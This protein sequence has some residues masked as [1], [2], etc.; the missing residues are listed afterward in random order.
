MLC[1][2]SL[3]WITRKQVLYLNDRTAIS[4]LKRKANW[5]SCW[6]I[7]DVLFLSEC[8]INLSRTLYTKHLP[9]FSAGSLALYLLP[10][11]ILCLNWLC[12]SPMKTLH[13]KKIGAAWAMK[14]P[15]SFRRKYLPRSFFVGKHCVNSSEA[16]QT[17]SKLIFS[18][19]SISRNYYLMNLTKYFP[20]VAVTLLWELRISSGSRDS[21]M[22]QNWDV[23]STMTPENTSTFPYVF[24]HSGRVWIWPAYHLQQS[25]IA[26]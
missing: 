16:E 9:F 15:S 1:C 12:S 23:S 24:T 8:L 14:G 2:T 25:L 18:R 10:S 22:V 5:Y 6:V 4:C 7:A 17:F 11:H 13:D 26:Q 3:R 21:L 19:V 20:M